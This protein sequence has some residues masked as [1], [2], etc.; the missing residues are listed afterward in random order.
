MMEQSPPNCKQAVLC[1][2]IANIEALNLPVLVIGLCLVFHVPMW[3]LGLGELGS[4]LFRGIVHNQLCH[5]AWLA[6]I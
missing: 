4:F 6:V 3:A 2:A 5:S 1:L